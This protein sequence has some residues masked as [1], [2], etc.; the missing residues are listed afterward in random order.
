MTFH[1]VLGDGYLPTKELHA[2]LQDLKEKALTDDDG[3]WFLV[4]AKAEPTDTERALV[5][6]LTDKDIYFDA[7]GDEDS[8]DKI[9]SKAQNF[10]KA[11]RLAPKVVSLMKAAREGGVDE[12]DKPVEPEEAVLLALFFSDEEGAREDDWL[13]DVIAAVFKEGFTVFAF[14]DGMTEIEPPEGE[15]EETGPEQVDPA[16]IVYTR[17]GLEEMDLDDLKKIALDK[18][19]EVQ[20]RSRKPTYIAAILGVEDEVPE[21]EME[22]P[23]PPVSVLNST[24]T[25]NMNTT[26]NTITTGS[27][28][29]LHVLPVGQVSGPAMLIVIYNG[30]VTSRVVTSEEAAALLS[31]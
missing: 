7:I 11:N 15:D 31:S 13:N 4:A 22:A 19:I 26:A 18:G 2:H 21:V 25:T 6:W 29:T 1:V 9:Y 5:K 27:S 24:P 17:A 30:T 8:A 23:P 12:D 3:F 20:P 10:H 28:A 14:N 16:D